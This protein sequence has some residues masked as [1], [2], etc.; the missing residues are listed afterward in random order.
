MNGFYNRILNVN[1]TDQSFEIET[2]PREIYAAYL[3]GKGLASYLLYTRNPEGVD[4]L[5]PDNHLIFAT[6][7]VSQ[8]LV[9]GGCRYGVFT[10]SPQTGFYSESYSGGKA[11]E[12]VDAAGFDAVVLHGAC[13][14]PTVLAITPE[15]AQF[16]PGE[17]FW[18]ME[19]YAAEDAITESFGKNSPYKKKG[20]VVI[21]PAS[22]NLVAFGVIE[23]DYWRSAGRT[24]V[25]TVMGSKKLKGL[26]FA[27]DKKRKPH[28]KDLLKSF[29]KEIGKESKT[30]P[31]V[32]AYK[33]MGTPMMVKMLNT[34]KAFP[35]K[36]WRKGVCD[37]WEKISADALH[38]QCDVRPN[39]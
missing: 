4:P 25:G 21:G 15:G 9:W 2:L 11:P 26:F 33:A 32:A 7:H 23:N 31:G 38:S 29:T 1:L 20:A 16:H 30:N 14:T 39:A 18:G 12:A 24:G 8:S 34:A 13:K 19:T 3:G 35:T 22:E 6:G 28:D 5:S 10:K 37:H 36:Y 17:P 27:G